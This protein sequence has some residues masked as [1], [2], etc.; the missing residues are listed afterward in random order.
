[1]QGGQRSPLGAGRDAGGAP[2]VEHL[3]GGAQHDRQDVGLTTEALD[4][5]HRQRDAVDGLADG[6]VVD[7]LGEGL[8]VDEH[9]DLGDASAG[10]AGTRASRCGGAAAG[11]EFEDR[12]DLE[13]AEGTTGVA[14]A[15]TNR[16]EVRL[17]GRPERG[18]ALGVEFEV[19]VPH[20]GG[21]VDP[22][23]DIGCRPLARDAI[24]LGRGI[25]LRADGS[26]EITAA[27]L[28]GIGAHLGGESEQSLLMGGE[29]CLGIG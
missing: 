9:L 2:D 6:G 5:L 4:G 15:L 26:C 3:T 8:P 25:E 18:V 28:E 12:L 10:G 11:H 22:L 19:G 1:M 24:G 27:T 29:G 7:A 16:G 21:A 17:D 13:L 14:V 23:A 20:A